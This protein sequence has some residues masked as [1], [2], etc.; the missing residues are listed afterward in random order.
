RP[1][2]GELAHRPEPAS[3]HGRIDA[4]GVG[5]LA[6]TSEIALR[7]P[8]LE[9]VRRIDTGDVKLGEGCEACL[10]LVHRSLPPTLTL[11]LKG[12]GMGGGVRVRG[13]TP[14]GFWGQ[15]GRPPRPCAGGDRAGIGDRP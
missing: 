5:E 11:P 10:A 1:E 8:G 4:A 7:V 6:G 12:G 9:V 14:G 3:I 15:P 13:G 2:T